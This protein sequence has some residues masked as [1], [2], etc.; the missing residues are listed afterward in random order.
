MTVKQAREI[1]LQIMMLD[2]DTRAWFIEE[3]CRRDKELR[4]RENKAE[5]QKHGNV[6]A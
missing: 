1:I 4:E 3:I 2:S 5:L 6:V